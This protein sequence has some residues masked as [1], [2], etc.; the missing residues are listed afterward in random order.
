MVEAFDQLRRQVAGR[1]QAALENRPMKP[2]V[3]AFALTPPPGEA[4]PEEV[5][6]PP[7]YRDAVPS[8]WAA[9][10]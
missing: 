6:P 4:E 1:F 5:T 10:W 7:P 2:I 3:D 9:K 8:S